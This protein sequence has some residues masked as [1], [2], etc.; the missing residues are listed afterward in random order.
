MFECGKNISV[1]RKLLQKLRKK[2]QLVSTNYGKNHLEY[3]NQI[4]L[5]VSAVPNILQGNLYHKPFTRSPRA[6]P[7]QA[8]LV[9]GET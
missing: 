3:Q 1:L 2:K 7:M 6:S 4:S 5:T 8:H 9:L